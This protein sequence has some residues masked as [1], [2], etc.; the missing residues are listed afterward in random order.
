[1]DA[2]QPLDRQGIKSWSPTDEIFCVSITVKPPGIV[3]DLF[4]AW[5][6]N[7]LH[8]TFKVFEEAGDF[9]GEAYF[10]FVSH[11]DKTAFRLLSLFVSGVFS[12]ELAI[13][14]HFKS[15][16]IVFLVF[17]CVVV[18]LFAFSA[19]HGNFNPHIGTS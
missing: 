3:D 4:F 16:R 7:F 18:A 5:P 9:S 17:D 19:S 14:A 1:M 10:F 8:L 6:N 15:V 12:A 11:Y 13:F 2:G